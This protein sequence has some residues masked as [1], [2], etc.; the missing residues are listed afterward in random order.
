MTA[1]D[2]VLRAIG[3]ATETGKVAKGDRALSKRFI[4]YDD[5]NRLWALTSAGFAV[6]EAHKLGGM[7]AARVAAIAADLLPEFF[8]QGVEATN[9]GWGA[10]VLTF[11]GHEARAELTEIDDELW[12]AIPNGCLSIIGDGVCSDGFIIFALAWGVIKGTGLVVDWSVLTRFTKGNRDW[13]L[14]SGTHVTDWC[15]LTRYDG[16]RRA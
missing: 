11:T 13:S 14:A 2:K 16:K 1:L 3:S 10:K 5:C 6:Q 9:P 15:V 12:E 4:M 7:E 8:E